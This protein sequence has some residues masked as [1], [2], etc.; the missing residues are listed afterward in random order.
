MVVQSRGSGRRYVL[1][2]IRMDNMTSVERDRCDFNGSLLCSECNYF[3]R[4]DFSYVVCR[5]LAEV[6][7][8]ARMRHDHIVCQREAFLEGKTL[9]IIMEY[10]EGGMFKR[11]Y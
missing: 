8:L 6:S 2:E 7:I 5:A 1:K 3:H 4:H 9:Q 10:A 11:C